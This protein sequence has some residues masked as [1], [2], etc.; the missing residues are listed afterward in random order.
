M[1]KDKRRRVAMREG[2]TVKLQTYGNKEV[3][4][5]LIRQD[6]DTLIVCSSEEYNLAQVE[7]RKPKSVGFNI[8]Y[9]L[10]ES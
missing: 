2:Q 10:G 3:M 9:L 4:L 8:K 5:Q 7:G 6:K 1:L